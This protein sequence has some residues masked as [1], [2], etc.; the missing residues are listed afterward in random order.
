MRVQSGERSCDECLNTEEYSEVPR[1]VD[2]DSSNYSLQTGDDKTGGRQK[3]PT[4]GAFSVDVV[5]I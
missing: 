1:K 5:D 3:S 2:Q 4:V